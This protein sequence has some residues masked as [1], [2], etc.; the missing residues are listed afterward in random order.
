MVK[1]FTTLNVLK[2]KYDFWYHDVTHFIFYK[3]W[4]NCLKKGEY[5]LLF[6]F[7]IFLSKLL[8]FFLNLVK[9]FILDL[10]NLFDFL[11][12]PVAKA[13]GDLLIGLFVEW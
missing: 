9:Y 7:L 6:K 11:D 12:F 2:S 1:Y 8:G 10:L 3:V 13:K 5:L 4:I